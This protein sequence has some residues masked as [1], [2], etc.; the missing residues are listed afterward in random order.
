[1]ELDCCRTEPKNGRPHPNK[2]YERLLHTMRKE[3]PQRPNAG[4]HADAGDQEERNIDVNP[5]HSPPSDQACS[6]VRMTD[7]KDRIRANDG[8]KGNLHD[9]D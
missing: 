9:R 3:C 4:E 5:F 7:A 6:V 1:M 2:E 8:G